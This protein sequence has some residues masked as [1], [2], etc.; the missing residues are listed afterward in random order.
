MQPVDLLFTLIWAGI[1][2]FLVSA[3]SNRPKAE[4][5]RLLATT[6][7]MLAAVAGITT[8]IMLL[9]NAGV[10]VAVMVAVYFFR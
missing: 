5:I 8:D 10:S 4:T 2:A 7:V 6:A 9:I 3:L 1:L